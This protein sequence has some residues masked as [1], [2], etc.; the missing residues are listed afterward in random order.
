M[1]CTSCG[2]LFSDATRNRCRYRR[3]S[4]NRFCATYETDRTNG[5]AAKVARNGVAVSKSILDPLETFP[6]LIFVFAVLFCG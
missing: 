5:S 2:T 3:R 1:T 4:R 6:N